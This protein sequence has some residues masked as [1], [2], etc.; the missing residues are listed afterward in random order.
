MPVNMRDALGP[1]PDMSLLKETGNHKF[2]LCVHRK[3]L[4]NFVMYIIYKF[5]EIASVCL[6]LSSCLSL[7]VHYSQLS[8]RSR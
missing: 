7:C 1:S 8:R 4:L 3:I 6:S 5:I 2:D